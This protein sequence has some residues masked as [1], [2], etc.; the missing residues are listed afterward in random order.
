MKSL[1]GIAIPAGAIP[2]PGA[3]A[4]VL[5]A[6]SL[7]MLGVSVLSVIFI[8]LGMGVTI[9]LTGAIVILAKRGVVRTL[10]GGHEERGSL[11]HRIIEIG[12]AGIL[13]L[14]GLLLFLAQL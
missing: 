14:F 12:G 4:V 2:C 10:A 1:L 8:S 13:F 3:V 5:F 6:L 11:L 9:S 7:H